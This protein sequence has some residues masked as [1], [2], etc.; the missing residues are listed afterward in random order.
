MYLSFY[1]KTDYLQQQIKKRRIKYQLVGGVKAYINYNL[2]KQQCR[3]GKQQEQQ[4]QYTEQKKI[5]TK[6][7]TN[8]C[9]FFFK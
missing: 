5:I 2:T 7:L 8:I 9:F 3:D 6:L 4:H 1:N